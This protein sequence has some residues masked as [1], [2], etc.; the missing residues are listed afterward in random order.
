[1]H[2]WLNGLFAFRFMS[3]TVTVSRKPCLSRLSLA[4]LRVCVIIMLKH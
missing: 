2:V 3:N 1:V 4:I